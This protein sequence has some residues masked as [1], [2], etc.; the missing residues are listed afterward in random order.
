MTFFRG[1]STNA[2][3]IPSAILRDSLCKIEQDGEM[4]GKALCLISPF[5]LFGRTVLNL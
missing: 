3:R 2:K 4:M 5:L 1:H